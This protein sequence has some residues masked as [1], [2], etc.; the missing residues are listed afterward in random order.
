ML[1]YWD[2]I[3]Q[4]LLRLDKDEDCTFCNKCGEKPLKDL[5]GGVLGSDLHLKISK[6][7]L[8]PHSVCWVETLEPNS[9]YYVLFYYLTQG[10]F[11]KLSY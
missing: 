1:H 11:F 8:P 7:I 5:S 3:R 9:L 6:G 2:Q 4:G 10:M